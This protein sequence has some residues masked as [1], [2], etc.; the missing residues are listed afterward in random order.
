LLLGLFFIAVGISMDLSVLVGRPV[1]LL[2]IVMG[3]VA[4]G[5]D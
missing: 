1:L 2:A 4:I 3:P 5:G